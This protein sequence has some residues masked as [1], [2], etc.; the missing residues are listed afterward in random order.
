MKCQ[1]LFSEKNKNNIVNLS[2]AELA[3]RVVKV[4]GQMSHNVRKRI[5]RHVHTTKIQYSH[6]LISIFIGRIL[7]SQE[8]ILFHADNKDSDQTMRMH[9]LI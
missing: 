1:N 9:R 6:S 8:C 3:Q 7:D 5:Y 2:Y 4:K